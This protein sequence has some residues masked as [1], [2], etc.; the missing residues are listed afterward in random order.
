[1]TRLTSSDANVSP[2][3]SKDGSANASPSTNGRSA[4]QKRNKCPHKG[5]IVISIV[6]TFVISIVVPS[7]ASLLTHIYISASVPRA[8]FHVH[9]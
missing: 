3:Q 4:S 2:H 7:V 9:A 5:G 8:L 6:I 1:M